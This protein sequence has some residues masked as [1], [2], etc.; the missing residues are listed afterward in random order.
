MTQL[1]ENKACA[2]VY[3]NNEFVSIETY[4]GYGSS[5]A[6]PKGKEYRLP[7][8]ADDRTLGDAVL[9]TLQYS[10]IVH[11]KEDPELFSNQKM[12]ERY[13]QWVAE[14]M[15]AYG[16]KSRR[17]L[18]KEMHSCSIEKIQGSITI[19]PRWHEKLEGW[20]ISASKGP[21]PIIIPDS[22]NPEEIGAALK[23]AFSRCR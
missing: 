17:A 2:E 5:R 4:S 8:D 10:R 19:F 14:L 20:S 3:K 22:S 18:F 15:A 12:M 9:D 1:V 16:Y 21:F 7:V 6:D 13:Q 23:L 11:P